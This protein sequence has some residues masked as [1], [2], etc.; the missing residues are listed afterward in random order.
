M[1]DAIG[2]QSVQT[3]GDPDTLRLRR[4]SISVAD[5]QDLIDRFK[6]L[7]L[8]EAVLITPQP[9]AY[10]DQVAEAIERVH[11]LFDEGY[12]R[13]K[14]QLSEPIEAGLAR[15]RTRLTKQLRNLLEPVADELG[16]QV[17]I[18]HTADG[19]VAAIKLHPSMPRN[20]NTIA[21]VGR[22]H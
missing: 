2:I 14:I 17:S 18:R 6:S 1:A 12:Q 3:I 4:R 7:L 22:K 21:G 11:Y 10:V 16:C 15:A 13:R 5:E 19:R 20:A 9:D 8:G